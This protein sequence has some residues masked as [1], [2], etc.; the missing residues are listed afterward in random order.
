MT[1]ETGTQQGGRVEKTQTQTRLGNILDY[2]DHFK[3]KLQLFP[4]TMFRESRAFYA[5]KYYLYLPKFTKPSSTNKHFCHIFDSFNSRALGNTLKPKILFG[6]RS[7][8]QG[9]PLGPRVG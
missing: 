1:K 5:H 3:R 2:G 9:G 4:P 8:L 7:T 6:E